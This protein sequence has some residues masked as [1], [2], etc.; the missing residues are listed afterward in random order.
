MCLTCYALQTA[1]LANAMATEEDKV[2]A[3]ISQSVEGYD[4][5]Q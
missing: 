5:S 2:K 1:D 3:M 4:P